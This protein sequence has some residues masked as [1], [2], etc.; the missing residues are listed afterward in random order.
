VT[1]LGE[2]MMGIDLF[3]AFDKIVEISHKQVQAIS[4]VVNS[5]SVQLAQ[6]PNIT[7]EFGMLKGFVHNL[8]INLLGAIYNLD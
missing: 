3:D 2:S 4:P 8:R 6:F 7:K 1:E 5:L